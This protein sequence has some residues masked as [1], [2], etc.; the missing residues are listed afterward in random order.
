M[1]TDRL[2]HKE[3]HDEPVAVPTATGVTFLRCRMRSLPVRDSDGAAFDR[4]RAET[5]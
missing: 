5:P 1:P 3:Q 4:F 2:V